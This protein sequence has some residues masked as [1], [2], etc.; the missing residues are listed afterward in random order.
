MAPSTKKLTATPDSL[1]D[2]SVSPL[3]KESLKSVDLEKG[4]EF[5]EGQV[6]IHVANRL[7]RRQKAYRLL[8]DLYS[9]MGIT[10]INGEELWLSIYD[11]LPDTTTFV[12]ENDQGCIEGA[13]TIVFGSSIGLPADDLYKKEIDK[14]R[15]AGEQVCEIVSLGINNEG[16]ASIKILAGLFY[17][18]F[19]HSWQRENTTALVIT[20]HSDFEDFYCQ[21]VSFEKL[22]PERNY[23]KVNG[24]PTV[25][26]SLSL[27]ELD[28]LRHQQRLFPFY[29]L[30]HSKQEELDFAK[31]IENM[32]LPMSDEEFFNFFIDKTNIWQ[33]ATPQQ[34][35]FIKEGYPAH[36]VNHYEVSRALA[37]GFSKK[38]RNAHD[39]R[40]NT[41]K[42]VAR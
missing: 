32:I 1:E 22:G 19:L 21:R 34:K 4:L 5:F 29:M 18:A 17:C 25:L 8:Y 26:L 31:S 10:Q 33:K 28:R 42:V 7:E 6:K 23:A 12:A 15:S 24:A 16:K 20:V 40:N 9:K 39:T 13:L 27:M 2:T 11:A 41:T 38:Y 30:K 35:D 3:E 36:E 14:I 37:K